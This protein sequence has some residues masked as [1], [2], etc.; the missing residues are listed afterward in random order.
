MESLRMRPKVIFFMMLT[1]LLGAACT[2][3]S[4]STATPAADQAVV[5]TVDADVKEI[6]IHATDTYP[7]QASVT[8]S[9]ELPDSCTQIGKADQTVGGKTIYLK[10]TMDR[11]ITAVC[12]EGVV[13]YEKSFPLD[14]KGLSAGKYTVNVNDVT[15]SLEIP[16]APLVSS[17]A[18]QVCPKATADTVSYVNEQEGF[19]L[20]QLLGFTVQSAVSNTVVLESPPLGENGQAVPAS[21]TIEA[22]PDSGASSAED[23]ANERLGSA[24]SAGVSQQPFTLGG[25]PAVLA[26]QVP[27]DLATRQ[28]FAVHDGTGYVLTLSPV[29][30]SA[31]LAYQ[32]AELLWKTVSASFT[33]IPRQA[34]GDTCTPNSQFLE[35]VTIPDGTEVTPGE[36]FIKTWSLRNTGTCTWDSSYQLVQIDADGNLL[37]ANPK[38]INL[39][40]TAPGKK[41]ELSVS[42]TVSPDAPAGSQQRAEFQLHAPNGELFGID[43]FALVVVKAPNAPNN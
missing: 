30:S 26:D 5:I 12:S 32:A 34:P 10:V 1:I 31:P 40:T 39:P 9:G 8:V 17:D 43:V 27:G 41:A 11:P 28:V 25:E 15:S 18:S 38:A 42:L 33:F 24:E 4:K 16:Q 35:D 14:V 13:P 6:Q 29:D 36:P 37:T 2:R 7:L 22:L 20:L 21:L 3:G 19:C 23:I